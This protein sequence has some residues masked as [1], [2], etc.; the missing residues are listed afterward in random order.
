MSETQD[1]KREPSRQPGRPANYGDAT[2]EEVA[3]RL[4][5]YRPKPAA[6]RS[7]EHSR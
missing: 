7:N 2:P 3:E 4:L 6:R 5:K 1:T